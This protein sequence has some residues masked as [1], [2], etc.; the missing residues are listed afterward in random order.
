MKPQK[1]YKM[2]FL[3]IILAC[4][5]YIQAQDVH[6]SQFDMTPMLMSPAQTC[7]REY[8]RAILNYKNQ[9][10]SV[11]DAYKSYNFSYDMI[12]SKR[13]GIRGFSAI[14]ANILSD[15]SG[16]SK[17]KTFMASLAYSYHVFLSEKSTLGGGVGGSYNQRSINT[18][19]LTWGSQY[20]G[21]A[22]DPSTPSGEAL[23]APSFS[24]FDVAGGIH[25]RYNKNEKY[26]TGNDQLSLNAG[27]S[28]FH[29][30]RPRYSFCG[31]D[32]RLYIR[33]VAYANGLIGISNTKS[34]LMPA[35]AIS[36]QGKSN[37]ILLGL[38]YKYQFQEDSRYTGFIKASAISFGGYYRNRDAVIARL[39]YEFS[40]YSIGIS[41]DINVS[42]LKTASNGLGG[43]EIALRFVNP[44]PFLYKNKPSL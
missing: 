34:S 21:M 35:F 7:D 4:S 11:A 16:D 10:S 33:K 23:S 22:F 18:D 12:L 1:R 2:T 31:T 5:T 14:G 43:I 44:S 26:M 39:M 13:K 9:W 28:A 29:L 37:E 25:W 6:F 36:M 30:T 3:G 24:F 17:M 42:G 15:N 20:D 27:I 32:E 41:Y 38:L 40:Q 19:A 8:L